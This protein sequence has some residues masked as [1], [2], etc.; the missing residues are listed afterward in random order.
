MCKIGM[1][2]QPVGGTSVQPEQ[3]FYVHAPEGCRGLRSMMMGRNL[4]PR[5][6][7]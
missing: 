6:T 7:A 5:S 3:R 4:R 2:V 1:Q